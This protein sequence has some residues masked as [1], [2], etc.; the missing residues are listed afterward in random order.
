MWTGIIRFSEF[1]PCN[2]VMAHSNKNVSEILHLTEIIFFFNSTSLIPVNGMM[3][4][5]KD[6]IMGNGPNIPV[7]HLSIIL[8]RRMS[9]SS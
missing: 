6:G 5:W 8:R 7:F 2:F 9:E 3:E 1:P 4:C